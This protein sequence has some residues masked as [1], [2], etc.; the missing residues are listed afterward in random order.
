MK[1]VDCCICGDPNSIIC[2]AIVEFTNEGSL[3][4]WCIVQYMVVMNYDVYVIN[5]YVVSVFEY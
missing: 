4:E 3:K 5:Y 1:V 2:F